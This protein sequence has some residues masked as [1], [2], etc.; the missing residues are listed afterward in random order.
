MTRK[1][2]FSDIKL[3]KKKKKKV[4]PPKAAEQGS[5]CQTFWQV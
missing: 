5:S 2:T 4:M 1:Q 3:Q